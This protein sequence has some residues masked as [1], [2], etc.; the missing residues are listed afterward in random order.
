M[1]L[2]GPVT[3]GQAQRKVVKICASRVS[4]SSAVDHLLCVFSGTSW[5]TQCRM[6]ARDIHDLTDSLS[7]S[8]VV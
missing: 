1:P 6:A 4:P 2:R 7:V 5:L 8:V 3:T